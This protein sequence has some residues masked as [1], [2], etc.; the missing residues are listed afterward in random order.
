VITSQFSTCS[1]I[2]LL[3]QRRQMEMRRKTILL[4]HNLTQKPRQQDNW[5]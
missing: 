4:V 5:S 2:Y 1:T 3:F